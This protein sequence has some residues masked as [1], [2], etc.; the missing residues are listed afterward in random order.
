MPATW[1]ED[2]Q[3]KEQVKN[4]KVK[5]KFLLSRNNNRKP[6]LE[7]DTYRLAD[8]DYQTSQKYSILWIKSSQKKGID[9]ET[10]ERNIQNC[11]EDLSEFKFEINKRNLNSGKNIKNAISAV[12]KK[13]RCQELIAFAI[14]TERR[15]KKNYSKKGRP[16]TNDES[17]LT[18]TQEFS[19]TF[20][21]NQDKI[22]TEKL[23]DGIFPLVTN[24]LGEY[25]ARKILETYKYQPFL[26]KRHSQLKTWQVITP[27]LFKK[28]TRI[29]SYI[30]MHVM[31]LMVSTLIERTIR[32]AMVKNK[33]D[34][35]PIYP[36]EKKCEYP[37]IYGIVR[38]F[39]NVERY[40]VKVEDEIIYFPADLNKTQKKF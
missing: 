15:Y 10:G 28:G 4:K 40:E 25:S 6:G 1:K 16:G 7:K 3:Y 38:L 14:N 19:I 17:K 18:W 23:T 9:E 30:Q 35:L 21:L 8:G 32:K 39:K 29:V 20:N 11:L 27:A 34:Y 12:L 31:E 5:W 13:R 37:T 36:D 33:I 24:V 26:E 22:K 2:A